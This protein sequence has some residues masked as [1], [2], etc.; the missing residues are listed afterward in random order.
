MESE[1]IKE[2]VNVIH[3]KSVAGKLNVIL[4]PCWRS[5]VTSDVLAEKN[6]VFCSS[7]NACTL[8]TSVFL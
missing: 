7:C 6:E 5:D 3:T 4:G 2:Q 1:R 8:K